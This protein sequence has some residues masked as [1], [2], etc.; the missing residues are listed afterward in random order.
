MTIASKGGMNLTVEQDSRNEFHTDRIKHMSK[1]I[2]S[3]FCPCQH[4]KLKFSSTFVTIS[5]F[6][7]PFPCNKVRW[8]YWNHW[9]HHVH[10]SMLCLEVTIWTAQ[11]FETKPG[12]VV[13]DH[14]QNNWVAV[15]TV[16]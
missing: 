8:V 15:I 6:P 10:V 1:G 11:P 13:Y 2:L 3:Q 5:I 4:Q 14:E 7:P 9:N 12:M 16:G